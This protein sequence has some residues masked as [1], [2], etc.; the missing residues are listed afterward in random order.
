MCDD[1]TVRTTLELDDDLAHVARQLASQRQMT[2]VA[3]EV[4]KVR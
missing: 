4:R 3:V 2:I 1:K